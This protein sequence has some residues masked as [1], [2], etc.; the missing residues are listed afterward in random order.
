MATPNQNKTTNPFRDPTRKPGGSG[1]AVHLQLAILNLLVMAFFCLVL[2]NPAVAQQQFAPPAQFVPPVYTNQPIRGARPLMPPQYRDVAQVQ[3]SD[4]VLPIKP[5]LDQSPP[6]RQP[7]PFTVRIKDIT[8][9]AGQRSNRIEGFGIVAGLKGTGGKGPATQQFAR[10]LLQNQGN[11]IDLQ[12]TKSLSVVFVTA[13][14]PPF[15]QPGEKLNATVSVW[16]DATS[17][18]GGTLVRTPLKGVDGQ[19]YALA[20]GPLEIGGFSAEGAGGSIKKNHDTSG[21]VEA[22]MEV[23]ICEGPAFNGNNIRLLLRNKDDTTAYRIASEI[24]KYFR[25]A[26]RANHS[27]SVDVTIPGSFADA[28]MDFLVMIKNLR[29]EPDIPARVV[30]NEK[31]G[32]IVIGKNVKLSKVVFAKDNLIITTSES[33]VASQPAPQSR[34]QTVVLP[35]TQIQATEQGGR[36]NTLNDNITVGDLATAL[37]MLGVTPQDLI[38]VFQSIRAE[39]SLH[40]ELIVQ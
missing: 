36:Y 11:R 38:S 32:T 35:R 26:A 17:L 24:N 5:E 4:Q 13:E 22:Q 31:T 25:R 39:G 6:T 28:K 29:V 21:R 14:V 12:P 8:T 18:Y 20:S 27:G 9:V 30:I 16:D 33:P 1:I 2:L 10:N 19:V 15:Y 7:A 3:F 40:A 23:A 37:N 34:G